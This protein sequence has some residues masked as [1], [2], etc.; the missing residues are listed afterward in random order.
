MLV[1]HDE[2]FYKTGYADGSGRGIFSDFCYKVKEFLKKFVG[3]D[4][5]TS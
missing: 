4:D 3:Q 5:K 2:Y 1:K